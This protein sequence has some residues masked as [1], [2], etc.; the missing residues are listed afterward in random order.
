M[1]LDDT[2]RKKVAQWIADGL[3]LSDI[4][5]RLASE[6]DVR[7]TY[8]DVRFLVDDLKLT[9]KDIEPPKPI[10]P[11]MPAAPTPA[12]TAPA[13]IAGTE[14]AAAPAGAAGSVSVSVDQLARPGAV[15]SGKVTF[16][17]GKQA[18]WYI[19]Q[20]GRLGLAPQQAGYRPSPADLQQFQILLESELGRMGM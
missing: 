14:S 1:T 15:V 8:M 13:P 10:V 17:D 20:S 11:A 18:D 19:D 9:P 5:N 12:A 7:M 2:Q 3:K 16:G 6:L 4:Q